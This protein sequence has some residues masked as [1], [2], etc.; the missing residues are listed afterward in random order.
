MN[1]INL[2]KEENFKFDGFALGGIG[3]K[4]TI[5]ICKILENLKKVDDTRTFHILGS[6]GIKKII[7]LFYS[8]ATSFDCHTPW[9]RASDGE[10]NFLIPLLDKNLKI[11]N[12]D[13]SLDYKKLNLLDNNY[14]CD[15]EICTNYP[16]IK[17]KSLYNDKGENNYFAKILIYFHWI[18]QY[19]RLLKKIKLLSNK[20]ELIDFIN[21]IANLKLKENIFKDIKNIE[22]Y[23]RSI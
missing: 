10:G 2:E 4:K 15:C 9:R 22:S 13:D 23:R 7:S 19:D 21:K 14:N 3:R 1:L 5:E 12:N 6:S 20:R 8:G 18:H 16:L 17:I 11:I